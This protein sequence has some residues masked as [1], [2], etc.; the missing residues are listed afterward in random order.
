[1]KDLAV[2]TW[3]TTYMSSAIPATDQAEVL[4]RIVTL[5]DAVKSAREKANS[6]EV[7]QITIGRTI[8]DHVFGSL[9]N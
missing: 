8:L 1:M 6:I 7:E 9:L 2:G 3:T 4:Q 5:Q